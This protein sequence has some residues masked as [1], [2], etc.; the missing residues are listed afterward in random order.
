MA[1]R[2]PIISL[3][4]LTVND[5][6]FNIDFCHQGGE[7]YRIYVTPYAINVNPDNSPTA[8]I[9]TGS[10]S[11]PGMAHAR[12]LN[13]SRPSKA[14]T[15]AQRPIAIAKIAE[16]VLAMLVAYGLPVDKAALLAH[17]EQ[18]AEVSA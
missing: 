6:Q 10:G 7:G 3:K 4:P 14:N 9:L 16:M 17:I 15:A 18:A 12:L 8:L 5:M 11:C 1:K 13:C 2:T